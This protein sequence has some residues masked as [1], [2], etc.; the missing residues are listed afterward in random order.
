MGDYT[1]PT[2]HVRV[3]AEVKSTESRQPARTIL[4]PITPRLA[5]ALGP[6]ADRGEAVEI[7][8]GG[9]GAVEVRAMGLKL[10]KVEPQ[11]K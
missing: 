7:V 3:L 8:P 1:T 11:S 5:L 4:K 9:N 10:K 6:L 2:G